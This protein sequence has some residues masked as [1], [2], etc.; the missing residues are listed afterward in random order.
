MLGVIKNILDEYSDKMGA[1]KR[2]DPIAGAAHNFKLWRLISTTLNLT[3]DF[4][5][6]WK[7][8]LDAFNQNKNG[9]FKET[10]LMRFME[11][12]QGNPEDHSNYLK[13][14]NLMVLTCNP[15]TRKEG[16]TK[17]SLYKTMQDN[18]SDTARNNINNFYEVR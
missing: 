10:M 16:L 4:K 12:M 3:Q 15:E 18:F 13:M 9:A 5:I 1:G 8:L 6:C 17:V 11:Q 2:I 14:V 7:V